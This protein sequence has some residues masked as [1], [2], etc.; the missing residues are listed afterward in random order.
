MT[1][2]N[3]LSAT[4]A[5]LA[6]LDPVK[7]YV[8]YPGA[9]ALLGKIAGKRVLDIGCGDGTF[10]RMLAQRGASVCG[11]DPAQKLITIA[12]EHETHEPLGVQYVASLRLPHA[13]RNAFDVVVSV[14]VLLYA[15]NGDALQSI[16]SDARQALQKGGNFCSVTFNPA[17]QRFGQKAYNRR[18]EKI[19]DHHLRVHF[20]APDG[21]EQMLANASYSSAAEHEQ[22]A[23]AAGFTNFAWHPLVPTHEGRTAMGA[24][25]WENFTQDSPYIGCI[26][27]VPT[28]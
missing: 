24:A 15:Q 2:Y 9:A 23:Q 13:W 7:Q 26:A 20:L 3:T 17:F 12:Q 1:Q 25:F 11:Y 16:F 28:S 5:A 19:D 14:M 27:S 6:Q 10:S 8:Q 18:F 22:A 4:Y 21:N